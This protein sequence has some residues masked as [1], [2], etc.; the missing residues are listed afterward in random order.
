MK[1]KLREGDFGTF[2]LVA[3]DGRDVLIQIDLDLPGVAATF[4]WSPCHCGETDGTVDCPHRTAGEM[5][6][7]ARLFLRERAGSTADDPGYF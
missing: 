2:L 4:G 3:E 1:I 6:D 5:I 7:E